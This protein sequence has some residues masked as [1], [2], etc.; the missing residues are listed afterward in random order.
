MSERM[1]FLKALHEA[2]DEDEH[3]YPVQY[4]IELFEELNAVW[5]E[6]VRE[7]RRMLCARLGTENPRLEDLKLI[8]LAPG[9]GDRPNFQFPRIWDLQDPAGY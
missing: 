4:C 8:A 5:A 1:T 7:S 6:S 2:H 9:D 3:A